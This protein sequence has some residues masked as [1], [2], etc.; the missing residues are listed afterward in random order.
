[1]NQRRD[2]T[3]A[4]SLFLLASL[5]MAAALYVAF[6]WIGHSSGYHFLAATSLTP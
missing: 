2:Q 6:T 1:M 5:L 3:V 4:F